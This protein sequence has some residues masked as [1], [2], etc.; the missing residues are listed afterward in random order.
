MNASQ[1]PAADEAPA[2]AVLIP[3]YNE[4]TTIANVVRGFRDALPQATIYVYDNGSTD[5]T[6]AI[7]ADAGAVV[8]REA[9]KGKGN[10]IRRMFGDIEA[11]IYLMVDG[12]DTYCAADAPMLI[13]HL[14]DHRLDLVNGLRQDQDPNAYRRGHRFGNLMFNRIIQLL[15][16]VGFNDVFSGY[17]VL[18]RRFV[19]SFPALSREFEIETELAVH[20]LTL[21]LPFDELPTE[22]RE[23]P[24]G[25]SSK[26]RSYRDGLRILAT[27]G[28][29]LKQERPLAFYSAIGALFAATAII[30][31][32]PVL[33][34]Y[35]QTGLVPRFPTAI[36]STGLML[37][38][39]L[40]I[41]NG[42]ILSA[43][44]RGRWE[45]KRMMYLGTGQRR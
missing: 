44:S 18:S 35:L 32:I 41:A 19:K 16:G 12:D 38:G 27:I 25:S 9:S 40:S 42:L 37:A 2:V 28:V 43:V 39:M 21:R 26:L 36:L 13:R 24:S 15:F 6:M 23:R 8:G 11:D 5:D 20:T 30:L 45:V 17:K 4:A 34:E 33:R 22:Y 31:F 3:C 10:V 7:A 1:A 14:I 29:L